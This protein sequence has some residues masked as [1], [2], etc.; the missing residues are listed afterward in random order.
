MMCL[1]CGGHSWHPTQEWVEAYVDYKIV[2]IRAQMLRCN[3]CGQTS[4]DSNHMSLII[5]K[6][7]REA[8]NGGDNLIG[9]TRSMI[10]EAGRL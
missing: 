6:L 1:S 4:A 5:A 9:V 8:Q 7:I 3:W 10:E 2:S